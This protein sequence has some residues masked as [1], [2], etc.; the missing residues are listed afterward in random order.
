MGVLRRKASNDHDLWLGNG[1][2][3]KIFWGF[4]KNISQP[5][6]LLRIKCYE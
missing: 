3:P 5:P 2:I 6:V 4:Y 1:A